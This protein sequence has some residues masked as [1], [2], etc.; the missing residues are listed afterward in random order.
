MK[1]ITFNT[2]VHALGFALC[3][4]SGAVHAQQ[5]IAN[6]L[7]RPAMS[8]GVAPQAQEAAVAERVAP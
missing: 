7:I 5:N 6:P 1:R 2:S 8:Q 3:I 4:A